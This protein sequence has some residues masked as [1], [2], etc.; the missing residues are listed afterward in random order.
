MKIIFRWIRKIVK[1]DHQLFHV[2]L[3]VYPSVRPQRKKLV[4][5]GQISLKFGTS[6]LFE[7]LSLKIKF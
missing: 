5:T 3:S 2:C 4:T 1:S 7:N 6:L